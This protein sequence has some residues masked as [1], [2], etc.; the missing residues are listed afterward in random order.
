MTHK[1]DGVDNNKGNEG[2]NREKQEEKIKKTFCLT[3]CVF[4]TLQIVCI[5]GRLERERNCG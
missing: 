2:E 4:L 5:G 1:I 3:F